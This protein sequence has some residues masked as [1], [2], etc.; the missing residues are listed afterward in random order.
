MNS[1]LTVV[2]TKADGV[3]ELVDCS[4]QSALWRGIRRLIAGGFRGGSSCIGV[5]RERARG[6]VQFRLMRTIKLHG[7]AGQVAVRPAAYS[8]EAS[9][10]LVAAVDETVRCPSNEWELAIQVWTGGPQLIVIGTAQ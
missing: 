1:I 5:A 2:Q 9:A 6:R 8:G 3:S 10:H 4:F 7:Q